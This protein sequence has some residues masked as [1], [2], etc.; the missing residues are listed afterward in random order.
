MNA[1]IR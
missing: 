1:E